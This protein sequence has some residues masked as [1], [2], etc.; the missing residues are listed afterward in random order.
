VTHDQ[1]E[2][3][4]MADRAVAMNEGIVQQVGSPLELYDN[5][6]NLF[7]A[8]FIGSPAMNFLQVEAKARGAVAELH[9]AGG[10]WMEVPRPTEFKGDRPLTLGL[11]PERIEIG[12]P[13]VGS[14]GAR[15]ELVE[16]TGLRTVVHFEVGGQFLKLFTTERPQLKIGENA[17]ITVRSENIRLFH[18]DTG[19]R[20]RHSAK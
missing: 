18:P 2:A 4:T 5:P 1:I 15:V 17:A 19:K 6:A 8:G 16:P 10:P 3:M 12:S 14:V 20:M 11:R 7:V 9:L 13:R